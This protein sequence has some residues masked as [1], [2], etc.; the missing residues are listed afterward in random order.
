MPC[1]GTESG[2]RLGRTQVTHAGLGDV[3]YATTLLGVARREGEGPACVAR[4]EPHQV[5]PREASHFGD[6]MHGHTRTWLEAES[7]S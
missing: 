4:E 7:A 3:E 2:R 1:C 5:L 6:R